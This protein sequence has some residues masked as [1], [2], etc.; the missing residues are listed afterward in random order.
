M[1]E[2]MDKDFIGDHGVGGGDGGLGGQ[3]QLSETDAANLPEIELYL[4]GHF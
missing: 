4:V 2:Q 1:F 3:V